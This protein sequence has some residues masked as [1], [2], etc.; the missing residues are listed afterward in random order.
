MRRRNSLLGAVAPKE[1]KKKM[2]LITI[3]WLAFVLR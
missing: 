1:K 2:S 3:N